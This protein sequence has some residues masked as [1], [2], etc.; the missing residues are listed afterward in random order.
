MSKRKHKKDSVFQTLAKVDAKTLDT[1]FAN[2][3]AEV[4]AEYDCLTC[5][6]CCKTTGPLFVSA[7]I[8]RISKH[9]H[10]RPG[11]FTEKYLRIDEDDDYVLQQVPC[12]FLLPDNRCSIYEVRPKA[13]REYP[14][15]HQKRQHSILQ[16]TEKNVVICPAAQ[17]IVQQVYPNIK[18]V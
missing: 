13:C 7:D 12:S 17:R 1:E 10:M 8:N 5:A 15:T 16:L 4:F 6:N 18:Q 9:L 2:A 14:H 11:S 3:D